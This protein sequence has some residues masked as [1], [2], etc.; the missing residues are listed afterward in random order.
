VAIAVARRDGSDRH[1]VL[2]ARDGQLVLEEGADADADASVSGSEDA[3]IEAL[4][5]EGDP[6]GLDVTGAS[7]AAGA[8]LAFLAPLAAREAAVA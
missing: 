5:P 3:W 1:Y 6:S 8:L 4:G 2:H 7:R